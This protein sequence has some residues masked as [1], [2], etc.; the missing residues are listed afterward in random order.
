MNFENL[1]KNN[2][3]DT[4]KIADLILKGE[5]SIKDIFDFIK[6]DYNVQAN[7]LAEEASQ[8]MDEVMS[9]KF[10]TTK[11]EQSERLAKFRHSM[12]LS[13]QYIEF[14]RL[15]YTTT[16]DILKRMIK[17]YEKEIKLSQKSEVL[18]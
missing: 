1:K 15:I 17:K 8:I 4:D 7:K 16:E 9:N 2:K 10:I 3:Y 12:M 13:D 14:K 6:N 11:K 18:K 5:I